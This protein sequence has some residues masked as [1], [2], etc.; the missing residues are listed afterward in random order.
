MEPK[1]LK[2]YSSRITP[3][4]RYITELVFNDF[5]GLKWEL[6]DDKRKL[7]KHPVINYSNENIAGAFRIIPHTLLFETGIKERAI[8]VGR[9][10]NLPVFFSQNGE[11]DFPFDV[12]AASFYLISRYEEYLDYTPDKHGRYPAVL[13]LAYRNA[14]L[15]IPVIDLWIREL[16][17]ALVMNFRHLA[18][19]RNEFHSVV[20]IDSDEAFAYKG[21][22][23]LRSV[24][25][26]VNE[27]DPYD[28]YDYILETI[29][30]SKSDSCFFF[31]VGDHSRF[32][33]N[34]SW[35]NEYYRKLIREISAHHHAGLH[36]S[37]KSA[38]KPDKLRSEVERMK[39]ITGTQVIRSRFHYL[40]LKF[41]ESYSALISMGICED[42]SMGYHDEPGFRAGISR[43]F[44]FY[45]I[46][47]ESATDLKVFP[48]QVMDATLF[49]YKKLDPKASADLISMLMTEVK[50]AGG[51][52]MSIWHNT[53]LLDRRQ[54]LPWREVFEFTVHNK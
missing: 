54:C 40:K 38:G 45:N 25:G 8:V 22:N 43:P 34:P 23:F 6:T 15:D 53:S 48:F 10:K 28:V 29:G 11:Q 13:S 19:K 52:F 47:T 42:F 30:H 49:T 17:K 20:T 26:F 33:R 12:M 1:P 2:I 32:D 36:P 46:K 37:Y 39:I 35:K 27:R 44:Y 4:L 18:F 16:S 31:P 41:P 50:R 7:G 14:F 24:G 51:T 21:R 3:R 5:F 9:W